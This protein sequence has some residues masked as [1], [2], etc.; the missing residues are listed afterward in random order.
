MTT[1]HAN[2][3]RDA[4]AR[5]EHMLLMT[6]IDFPARAMRGQIASAIHVVLQLN[7]LNDGTRRVTAIE[8]LIGMEG[9]VITTQTVFKFEQTGIDESGKVVGHLTPTGIRSKFVEQMRSHGIDL[10]A[11]VFSATPSRMGG[12]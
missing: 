9:D 2:T 4:L 8:E 11:S 7:R 1:I 5:L 3:P 10:P 12:R 6:G